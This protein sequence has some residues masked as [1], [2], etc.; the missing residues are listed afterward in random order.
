VNQSFYSKLSLD[1]RSQ[2]CSC[3]A[4]YKSGRSTWRS[5]LGS[6]SVQSKSV[7]PRRVRRLRSYWFKVAMML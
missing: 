6:K 7:T 2:Y 3:E 1:R 5:S 4:R